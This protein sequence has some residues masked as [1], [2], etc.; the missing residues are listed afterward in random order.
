MDCESQAME[1]E[2]QIGD[3]SNTCYDYMPPTHRS[4]RCGTCP[5]LFI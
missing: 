1:G 3:S 2:I 4:K 5:M